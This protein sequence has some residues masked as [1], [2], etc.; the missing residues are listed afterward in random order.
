[1]AHKQYFFCFYL[2]DLAYW[3]VSGASEIRDIIDGTKHN[4][5]S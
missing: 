2:V 1:M 5:S 4:N 3:P